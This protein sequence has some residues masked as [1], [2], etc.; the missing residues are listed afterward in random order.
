MVALVAELTRHKS[1]TVTLEFTD[2]E[3]VDAVLLE[4]DSDEHEDI[5]FDVVRVRQQ[6]EGTRY[7]ARNVYVAPINTVRRVTPLE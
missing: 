6:I 7:D 1:K 4:V 3:V 5:T 2:G